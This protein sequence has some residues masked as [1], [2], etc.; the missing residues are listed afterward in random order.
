MACSIIKIVCIKSQILW[1]YTNDSIRKTSI[2]FNNI[3]VKY[4]QHL[5]YEKEHHFILQVKPLFEIPT[6]FRILSKIRLDKQQLLSFI[7]T[8]LG[9]K[10][11]KIKF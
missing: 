7:L 6:L 10:I 2:N 1:F 4:K 11:N 5:R 8:Y 9:Y 3:S